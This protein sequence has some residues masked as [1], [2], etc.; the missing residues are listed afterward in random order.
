M[1]PSAASTTFSSR[2]RII[3]GVKP[4]LTSRRYRVCIGGSMLSIIIRC[5]ASTSSS[6]SWNRVA[7]RDDEKCS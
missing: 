1:M 5:W 2:S 6:K 3:R 7:A 4:L